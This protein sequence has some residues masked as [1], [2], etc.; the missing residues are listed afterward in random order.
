VAQRAA[1]GQH[2]EVVDRLPQGWPRHGED[3][4]HADH[5]A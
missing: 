5:R 3:G 1:L 2:N 4:D